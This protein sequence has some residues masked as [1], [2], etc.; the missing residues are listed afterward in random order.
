MT[1]ANIENVLQACQSTDNEKRKE[2]EKNLTNS[3]TQ[4]PGQG[5]ALLV[6]ALSSQD[7]SIR[8]LAAVLI[9]RKIVADA[10][11]F[12]NVDNNTK[13][14]LLTMVLKQLE[15]EKC[16]Q[17]CRKLG[18]LIVELAV[19]LDG[20][21]TELVKTLLALVNKPS[22][23]RRTCIY[24]LGELA[25]GIKM[26]ANDLETF[27]T[28]AGQNFSDKDREIQMEALLMF[29]KCICVMETS[30]VVKYRTVITSILQLL[31]VLLQDKDE[32]NAQKLLQCLIEIAAANATFYRQ[33]ITDLLRICSELCCEGKF[34]AGTKTLG[35]EILCTILESEPK[36]VRRNKEF[37]DATIRICFNLM[38]G[39][40][41][42]SSWDEAY[43]ETVEDDEN[44][45]A[46]QV[47]LNRLSENI[48][49]A[50]FLPLLMP[51]LKELLDGNDWRMRHAGFVAMA[52]CCELF[53][54]NKQNK[55]ELFK[56]IVNGIQDSHYRVRYAAIHCLGI[57]CSDFGKKFV[58][59]FSSDILNIF[60]AGMD[61]DHPRTQAH[62]AICIVNFTE[63]VSSKLLRPRLEQLLRKLFN[64]LKKPEKFVQENALSAVSE[65]A[66]NAQEEFVKFYNDFTVPLMRILQTAVDNEYIS[67]RLEALRCL[68]YIGVAVGD[69]IFNNHAV[70]AMQISL[71]IIEQ[72][73]VEVVRILNSWRRIFQTCQ[74][75]MVPFTN[76]V[77]Q[78]VFKYI[79]Q[80]VRMNEA[81]FDEEDVELND[82]DQPVNASRVEEKVSAINLMYAVTKYSKGQV[83]VMVEPA[84][85]ILLSLIDEP[86]D[87][88]ILEAAAEA[89]PGLVVCVIDAKRNGI[90]GIT[91]DNVKCL[92]NMVLEKVS[93]A[94][95][96][97]ESPDSLCSFAICIEKSI[98][99]NEELTKSMSEQMLKKVYAALL[100]CLKES[101]DRMG[102]RNELMKEPD[103]DCE[104]IDQL[105]E[106]NEQE[107]TLSNNISDAVGA[108]VQVY[109]D[110]FIPVLQ[111]EWETLNAMISPDALDIQTRASLYIFCDVV[112]HCSSNVLQQIQNEFAGHFQRAASNAEDAV[113]R[114]AGVFALGLLFEKSE[115]A[116][117]SVISTNDILKICFSQFTDPRYQDCDDSENVQ[118]NA[119][120]TIGRI[121][122]YCPTLVNCNEVY[123]QWL[124]CFPIRL[125]VDCSQWCYTEMIRL[126][127]ANNEA[128]IGEGG[129]NIA[130]IVNWIAE[131]AYTEMSNE[132]LDQSL[133]D[134]IKK[135]QSNEM[136]MSRIKSEMPQYLMEKMEQHL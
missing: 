32:L 129:A 131:V 89:L 36:M 29:G 22:S 112:D 70:Q 24:I 92:F 18:D 81:D 1:L 34:E 63:K 49:S 68:T 52:Q 103:T 77:A 47:G 79:S 51:K 86:E 76:Q 35:L 113:V 46:G 56:M 31:T 14:E 7:E 84:A 4:N 5:T 41:E 60:E 10:K 44:F 19:V 99:T 124:N 67:L 80:S 117:G 43:N 133:T 71:P 27:V 78:I 39:I 48:N 111:T 95:E 121:C 109:R 53:H 72:D 122:K 127:D 91:D 8:G 123:P 126:I 90:H 25:A 102:V 105:K 73:G 23:A 69:K 2:A 106:Y 65:C 28:L 59:K 21:W 93:K 94:M 119:A 54:E 98:K 88:S 55:E 135:V 100:T 64:L 9:R 115:G 6:G 42:D 40:E 17:A 130:K 120:M 20:N 58:N 57:M 12:E 75:A 13:K 132:A 3:I 66:D 107:A 97:E 83:A 45:D 26:D 110:D 108:L 82:R 114:Q 118:D 62:S 61:E 50:K 116:V 15:V 85:K 38:L 11:I 125:E 74:E 33:N 101:A 96:K 136:I 37:I 104:D 30:D 87:D 134:L 128:L 16:Y